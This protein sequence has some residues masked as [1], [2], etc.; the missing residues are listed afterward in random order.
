[1]AQSCLSLWS[2]DEMCAFENLKN[3]KCFQESEVESADIYWSDY[4]SEAGESRLSVVRLFPKILCSIVDSYVVN[5][6]QKIHCL[7]VNSYIDNL[8]KK[9]HC[10]TGVCLRLLSRSI[11]LLSRSIFQLILFTVQ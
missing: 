9:F 5:L 6:L 8:L 1:M 2:Q 4:D 7:T 11:R 10:T 3:K